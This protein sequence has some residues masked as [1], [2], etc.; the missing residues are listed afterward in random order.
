MDNPLSSMTIDYWYKALTVF[1]IAL[2]VDMKG[3]S[4]ATVLKCSL[5]TFL[6]GLGEWVNHPLQVA[7]IPRT[8][9]FPSSTLSS[10]NRKPN[11]LGRLLD[12]LGFLLL[13]L[14]AYPLLV[15]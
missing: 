13:C 6:I 7:M 12:V 5:G 2:T 1:V 11:W 8:A 3:V 14:G 10:H 9:Y 4:N 15:P